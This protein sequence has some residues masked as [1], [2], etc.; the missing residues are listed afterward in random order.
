[1]TRK[2][3]PYKG[4]HYF[5]YYCPTG[6]KRGCNASNMVKENN[7]K[8]C[9][10][11]SLKAHI[12]SLTELDALINGINAD[13]V[14]KRLIL[15]KTAQISENQ[16]RIDK[17]NQLKSGLF[18]NY[19][20]GVI[21]KEEFGLY[22]SR[23]TSEN[24]TLE[25]ANIRLKGEVLE[26]RENKGERL[27]WLENFKTLSEKAEFDRAAIVR[28]IQSITIFSK[29]DIQITFNYNQEYEAAIELLN[30]TNIKEAV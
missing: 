12:E 14:N 22:K 13:S 10:S 18:D 29:T 21:T 15:Q 8:Q 9:V 25:K 19:V 11:A 3:V 20:N 4:N 5:Y 23:Y 16:A 2:T 28:L 17:Y 26:L 24:T 7:L 27:K 30:E 1:M 6:K